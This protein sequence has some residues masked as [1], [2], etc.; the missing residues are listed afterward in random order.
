MAKGR[1]EIKRIIKRYVEELKNMGIT[2][3]KI[4]IYGSYAKGHPREGS[5]IDII[6]ISN[7]FRGKNLRERLEILGLAAGRVF[8]PIEARGYTED[9]ISAKE[10]GSFLDEVVT[11][12]L[13]VAL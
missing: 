11:D 1:Q 9:E 10:D 2:P 5:D 3:G 8:E 7:D 12:G 6:V 13:S 4:M